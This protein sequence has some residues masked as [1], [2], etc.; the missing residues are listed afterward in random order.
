MC[1]TQLNNSKIQIQ[2]DEYSGV[3]PGVAR[4][5]SLAEE[6]LGQGI[7]LVSVGP[8]IHNRVEIRRLGA[9][10]LQTCEQSIFED[11][12]DWQKTLSGKTL[13]IRAHGIAPALREKLINA[14]FSLIDATCPI[15]IRSQQLVAHYGQAGYQIILLGKIN[16]PEIKALAGCAETPP[17]IINHPEQVENVDAVG[18]VFVIAQTTIDYE[19]FKQLLKAIEARIPEVEYKNTI[20]RAMKARYNRLK[21]F[22][23]AMDLIIFVG[24]HNSSNTKVLCDICRSENKNSYH[25][26]DVGEIDW[27]WFNGHDRIGIAGSASTPVWQLESIQTYLQKNLEKIRT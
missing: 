11:T 4:A 7:K 26:E 8:I 13:L 24:G 19:L 6:A 15:V 20:C 22:A 5:I 2:I 3:C 23:R 9:L 27:R 18:K 21:S 16:H 25:I 12:T 17:I 1:S 10:G 14:N